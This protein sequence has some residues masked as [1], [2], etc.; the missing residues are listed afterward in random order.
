M[1]FLY[2][3]SGIFAVKYNNSTYFYRKNAQNDI[4]SLLDIDGNTVVKYKYDAWGN[5][6]VLDAN[7]TEITDSTHIGILNPFRY[8]S[9][10]YDT[11]TGLY[12]LKARYYD[13]ET[14]R[15][16][17]QDSIDFIVPNHIMGLNLYAYCYNNPIKYID[18]TGKIPIFNSIEREHVTIPIYELLFVSE[19]IGSF[20]VSSTTT[21]SMVFNKG[22][23]RGLLYWY[24]DIGY[25]DYKKIV[26]EFPDSESYAFGINVFSWLGAEI[27]GNNGGNGFV[28]VQITPWFQ[29]GVQIGA[30]GIGINLWF[31]SKNTTDI[32]LRLDWGGIAI[33]AG[34]IACVVAPSFASAILSFLSGLFSA[35]PALV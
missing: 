20:S 14:G 4:I 22:D 1:E 12:Y 5:T 25:D 31:G 11:E 17:S 27:G 26:T 34:A 2:D 29:T 19:F 23:K 18:K 28:N 8:R 6:K 32:S 24:H 30:D 13:F 9:Y 21:E 15:F 16:I 33:I 10:Y 7:G 35:T 3:H